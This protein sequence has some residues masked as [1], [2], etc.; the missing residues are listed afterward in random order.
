MNVDDDL[1]RQAKKE[2]LIYLIENIL[3][4]YLFSQWNEVNKKLNSKS[5]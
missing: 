5:I 3:M 2:Y 4:Y 1:S